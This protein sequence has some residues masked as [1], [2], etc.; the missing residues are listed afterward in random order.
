MV[1]SVVMAVLTSPRLALL[2]LVL[3][4]AILLLL[5]VGHPQDALP[6]FGG[7]QQR[8]D[9][10]NIVMQENLAGVRVVKAFVRGLTSCA[11]FGVANDRPHAAESARRAHDGDHDAADHAHAQCRHRGGRSGLAAYRCR[12]AICKSAR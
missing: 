5:V 3:L 8:L 9:A 12:L 2:F 7:V 10:L 6:L 11:R 1:G 4:P